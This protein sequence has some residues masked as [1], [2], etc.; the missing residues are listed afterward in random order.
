MGFCIEADYICGQRLVMISK[1]VGPV[2]RKMSQLH[3]NMNIEG[4]L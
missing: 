3:L 2:S 1:K 4:K